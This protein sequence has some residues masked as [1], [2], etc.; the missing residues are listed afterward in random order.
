[1]PRPD[2]QQLDV[3]NVLHA[4]D[5]ICLLVR[6]LRRGRALVT[7]DMLFGEPGPF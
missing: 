7:G 4:T 2:G 6:D 1:M 5:S 3:S